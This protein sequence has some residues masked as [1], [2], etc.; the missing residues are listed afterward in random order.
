MY[1]LLI[2]ICHVCLQENIFSIKPTYVLVTFFLSLNAVQRANETKRTRW[3]SLVRTISE[4]ISGKDVERKTLLQ[5]LSVQMLH[6][7]GY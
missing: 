2:Y 5:I 3:I 6:F 7:S 1:G 4:Y